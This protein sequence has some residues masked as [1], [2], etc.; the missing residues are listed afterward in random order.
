M[1]LSPQEEVSDFW[2]LNSLVSIVADKAATDG[3]FAVYRQVAPPGF[4]TPYHTHEAYGEGF[5]VLDGEV[6]FFC[7]GQKTVVGEGGFLYLPGTKP[8]GFRVSGEG[9][10]TMMIVSPA[11]STFGAFVREMGQPA[12]ADGLP[13]PTQIDYERLGMLSAKYGSVTLGPLPG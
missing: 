8:H 13:M 2:F 7:D 12:T 6:T 10:A 5:C 1:S 9:V 4:A 11:T 3:S